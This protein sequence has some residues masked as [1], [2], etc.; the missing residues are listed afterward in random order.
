MLGQFTKYGADFSF[1]HYGIT[2]N[3]SANVGIV[4]SSTRTT[5]VRQNVD[6]NFVILNLIFQIKSVAVTLNLS[7][8][9]K[10][11]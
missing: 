1:D 5:N 10:T 11:T 6:R 3:T 4:Y 8:E 7:N 9:H 2:A